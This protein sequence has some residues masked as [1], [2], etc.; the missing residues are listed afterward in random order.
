M[1]SLTYAERLLDEGR[2]WEGFATGFLSRQ[3]ASRQARQ[4]CAEFRHAFGYAKASAD[5]LTRPE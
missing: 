4:A 1:T 2:F 5:M 3:G